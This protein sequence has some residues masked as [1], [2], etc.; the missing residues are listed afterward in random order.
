MVTIKAKSKGMSIIY[1]NGRKKEAEIVFKSDGT[2]DALCGFHRGGCMGFNY[3]ELERA[4]DNT[5]KYL[6]GIH[7]FEGGCKIEYHL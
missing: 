5:A 7:S 1:K 3:R 4:K 6:N 2:Y